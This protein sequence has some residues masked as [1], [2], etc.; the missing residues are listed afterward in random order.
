MKTLQ[1]VTDRFSLIDKIRRHTPQN[2]RNYIIQTVRA[3]FNDPEVREHIKLGEMFGYYG[4]GRRALQYEKDGK[5]TLPE[6]SVVLV[7]GKP[8]TLTNVPSNRTVEIDVDDNGIVTHTQEILDT[9]PGQIVKGMIASN[10]G[11]WSWVTGGKDG[12]IRSLVNNYH[13]MDYVTIPNYVSLDKSSM[14]LESADTRGEQMHNALRNAGYSDNAATDLCQHFEKMRSN[15]AMLESVE[16]TGQLESQLWASQ[17]RLME[18]EQRLRDA[19]MMLESQGDSAA[20]RRKILR[21]AVSEL[22]VFLSKEQ[23]Q[24]LIRM[25]TEDDAMVFA[26][27]LESAVGSAGATLPLGGGKS[28]HSPAPVGTKVR[29][30]DDDTPA[31]WLRPHRK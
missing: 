31:L 6:V 4:H 21:T 19:N 22:P 7:E 29:H 10:A 15:Q 11:G 8:V 13:G 5:L 2:D 20:K 9:D 16:R 18:V 1:T 14:M 23:K 17:G 26:A 24:A 28:A 30:A 3:T 25:E 12:A 27:M